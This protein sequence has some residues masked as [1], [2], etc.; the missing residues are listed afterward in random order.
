MKIVRC[1][2]PIPITLLVEH[3]L[4]YYPMVVCVHAMSFLGCEF[5][6]DRGLGISAQCPQYLATQAR[7]RVAA[8]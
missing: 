5:L 6:E 8:Q 1:L 4:F 7:L 2:L 3:L